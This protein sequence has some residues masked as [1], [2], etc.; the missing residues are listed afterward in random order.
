MNI[1]VLLYQAGCENEGIHSLEINEKT[2]VLMF[3]E[4]DDAQRYCGLLEAQDFPCPTVESVKKEEIEE[5]CSQAGYEARLVE[6]GFI[7]KSQE[8][9]LMIS[10]PESNLDVAD[11]DEVSHCDVAEFNNG[12]NNSEQEKEDS[13]IKSTELDNIRKNLEDLL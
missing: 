8:D 6:R 4:I 13:P 10:P 3:E 9:R 1:Y 7:P 11:W 2:V 5:F 12:Q